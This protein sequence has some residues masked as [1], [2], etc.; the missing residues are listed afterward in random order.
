MLYAAT[1]GLTKALRAKVA[2]RAKLWGRLPET[3]DL[4]NSNIGQ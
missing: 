3:E 4:K 1:D 2:G